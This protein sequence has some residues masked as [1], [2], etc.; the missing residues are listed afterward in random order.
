MFKS[1]GF[2]LIEILIVIGI[3]AIIATMVII[4]INPA[5]QFA[6]ARNT[7]RTS[8]AIA[9]LN[10]VHQRM[11]DNKGLFAEGSVCDSLP[12]SGAKYITSVN[13]VSNVDL[14]DCLVPTYLAAMPYDP[15]ATGTSFTDC[16]NYTSGYTVSWNQTT[17]R[18]T[19]AAPSAELG[20]TISVTR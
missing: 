3:I 1:K 16:T 14:C 15:S 19:V 6:A 12:T 9:I 2:T 4:A 20:E 17:S 5:R 11:V 7:K 13:G 10:A 8:D 18:M